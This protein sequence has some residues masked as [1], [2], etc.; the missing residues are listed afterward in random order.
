VLSNLVLHN[1]VQLA[2]R[3]WN[4]IFTE[5]LHAGGWLGREKGPSQHLALFFVGVSSCLLAIV[6]C[7]KG[8][9]P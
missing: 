5:V 6:Q 3:V 7:C 2:Y 9:D 8:W 4:F 1:V